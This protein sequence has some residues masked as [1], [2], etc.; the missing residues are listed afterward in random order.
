MNNNHGN[1]EQDAA[2]RE[3]AVTTRASPGAGNVFALRFYALL[4]GGFVVLH[5]FAPDALARGV[6]GTRGLW[7]SGLNVAMILG[8]GMILGAIL[9][10][11]LHVQR[12]S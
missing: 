9:L 10:A 11:V 1:G 7:L 3:P 2:R 5:V 12:R 4:F 8:I 6:E